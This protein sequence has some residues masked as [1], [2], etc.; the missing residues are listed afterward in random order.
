MQQQQPVEEGR[1]INRLLPGLAALSAVSFSAR[2]DDV[3]RIG[4]IAAFSGPFADYGK[5]TQG[6]I[7]SYLK[8]NGNSYFNMEFDKFP[9]FKDPTK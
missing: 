1:I 4:V 6:G 2:A 5:Q 3:I 7:K 9:N 8:R